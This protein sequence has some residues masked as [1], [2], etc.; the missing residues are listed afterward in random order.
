MNINEIG[1]IIV[2]AAITVHR[3]LGPGL[4]ESCYETCLMYE[5]T[6]RGLF[7]ERQKSI[8]IIY[9]LIK[10]ESGYKIDLL[11]EKQI[12]IEL[13]SV[14]TLKDIH[15]AQILTYMKLG[16]YRLGYLMNFNERLMKNGI[17]R[18]IL[19]IE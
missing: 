12:V 6:T 16:S 2:D 11:V 4:L 17:K 9:G 14:E 13:K 8:P 3:L 5:L 10:L 1:T 18:Y 15:T 19:T 7:V